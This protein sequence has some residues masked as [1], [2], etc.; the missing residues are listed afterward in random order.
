MSTVV[1]PDIFR[2]NYKRATAFFQMLPVGRNENDLGILY[3]TMVAESNGGIHEASIP[4]LAEQASLDHRTTRR[5][6]R[7]LS[8]VKLLT[9]LERGDRQIR[10]F[11]I[12][13]VPNQFWLGKVFTTMANY[14]NSQNIFDLP[15]SNLSIL[16]QS[17]KTG[18]EEAIDLALYHN[19][20]T[21]IEEGEFIRSRYEV[22]ATVSYDDLI[23][24][25]QEV[26]ELYQV[27]T[28]IQDQALGGFFSTPVSEMVVVYKL[29]EDKF[30]R[31]VKT[32]ME[33]GWMKLIEP[34]VLKVRRFDMAL[35]LP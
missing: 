23:L 32:A 25:Q 5:G 26:M 34:T 27:F 35:E 24:S 28:V 8:F 30:Y 22:K 11:Q 1:T 15:L 6:V 19:L 18:V 16:S 3:A 31:A 33:L 4:A 12:E 29:T 13:E 2:H 14:A 10:R 9:E 21:E 7:R 17:N 20:M